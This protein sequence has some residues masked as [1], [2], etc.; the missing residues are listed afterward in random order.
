MLRI[1]ENGGSETVKKGKP[2]FWGK[3]LRFNYYQFD[4]SEIKKPGI[5]QVEYNGYKTEP[6]KI[7]DDVYER[8]VWQPTLEY[9]LPVQMCHMRINEGYRVW[10]D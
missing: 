9:F 1:S 10:H 2:E 7:G 3:Y 5:Y 4:F 6:F 8:H